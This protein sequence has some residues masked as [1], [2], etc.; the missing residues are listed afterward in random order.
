MSGSMRNELL[1]YLLGALDKDEHAQVESKLASD[2][3]LQGD[4]DLLR[5]GLAP[6][7][8]DQKHFEPPADLWRRT[9]EYVML[10]AGLHGV[11]PAPH[12]TAVTRP[13]P[14]WTEA[15]AP[16]RRWRMADVSVAAGIL[17]AALSVVVPALIQSRANANRLA[18]QERLQTAHSGIASFAG[19]H[20]GALPVASL[21]EGFA[22]K[23]GIYAPRLRDAG[24]F[25]SDESVIC[26]ASKLAAEEFAIPS[27]KELES[28]RGQ[29]LARMVQ[30]MGGSYAF[31]IGYREGG[32]YRPLTLRAGANFPLMADSP[33][34]NGRPKGH[35]G[36]C[37]QNVL[38]SDGRVVYIYSR[39]WPGSRDHNIFANENGE[40]DAGVGID[41]SVL[42][43]SHFG[44]RVREE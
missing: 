30:Q 31:A 29:K 8:A 14:A 7:E 27:M 25:I 9:V 12:A 16:T 4:A 28:A 40:L 44:P 35:H 37:G 39:C 24:H 36:A 1:G 42:L 23:A 5:K 38:F 21:S 32:R 43:P 34:E 26:P 17:V 13:S 15:A 10:R 2:H 33:D 41:D 19:L 3:G 22:G 20:N 18:C 11:G 6:L